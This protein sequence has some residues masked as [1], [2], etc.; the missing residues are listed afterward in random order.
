[1]GWDITLEKD[2][3]VVEVDRH[4]EGGTVPLGGTT[5]ASISITYNYSPLFSF[6]VLDGN[7]AD[8]TVPMLRAM[9]GYFGV[10]RS[11]NYWD[12]TPGNVGY[13]CSILLGW[14][15]RH[16]DAVWRVT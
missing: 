14:A 16:R 10:Y 9:V 1:M 5:Q 15:E 4:A 6:R 12:C 8:H 3:E 2:G 11:R 7:R 13:A